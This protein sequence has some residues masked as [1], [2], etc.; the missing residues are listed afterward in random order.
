MKD[1]YCKPKGVKHILEDIE[2]IEQDE[3]GLV[4]MGSAHGASIKQKIIYN[5]NPNRLN[6]EIIRPL[7]VIPPDGTNKKDN[8]RYNIINKGVP[9]IY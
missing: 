9:T 5:C 1:H 4:L 6:N 8:T 7:E 2:T 3:D